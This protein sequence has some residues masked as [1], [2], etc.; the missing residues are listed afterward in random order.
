MGIA[1]KEGHSQLSYPKG[2]RGRKQDSQRPPLLPPPE[3]QVLPVPVDQNPPLSPNTLR[4]SLLMS[5]FSFLAAEKG[6]T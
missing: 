4:K 5:K 6:G 1:G 2:W 3:T